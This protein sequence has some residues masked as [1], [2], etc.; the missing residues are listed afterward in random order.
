MDVLK[1]VDA[2][3]R[4]FLLLGLVEIKVMDLIFSHPPSLP[5]YVYIHYP[6]CRHHCSYCDFNV[7][8]ADDQDVGFSDL[9]RSALVS[10]LRYWKE[11]CEWGGVSLKGLY[12]GGGTP[13]LLSPEVI[14]KTLE[15]LK[16][17][18]LSFGDQTEVTI[19]CNP[20]S[21][22]EDKLIGFRDCGI[23]RIS[24]GIQS[25]QDTQL[26]R[27]ERLA[28]QKHIHASIGWVFKHFKNFSLD[29]MLG[30]PDQTDEL[31]ER[32]LNEILKVK[33]PHISAYILTLSEDHVWK[34]SSGMKH[35]MIQDERVE[36]FYLRLVTEL[37]Q[38]GFHHYEVSNF[39]RPGSES[40]HNKNYW[41]V[42]SSYL[43]LGPGAHGY[44]GK[45]RYES[46]RDPKAWMQSHHGIAWSEQLTLE[47][48]EIE[49]FYMTLR[50]RQPAQISEFRSVEIAALQ[51]AALI[52]TD[53]QNQNFTLTD[54]GWLLIESVAGRLVKP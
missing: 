27:L 50:T 31:F 14:R 6:L 13:S 12:L 8:R 2:S 28:T 29:L 25:F 30:L 37:K 24:L 44:L 34:T 17:E 33:P 11:R 3:G 20:E 54:R 16:S 38:A 39:A 35:R 49:K 4:V 19:E 53:Q 40:R 43:G 32:D 41:D 5:E 46:I 9:W 22:T 26:R 18:G 52:Q 51:Q 48:Q 1:F 7:Y 23:N 42:E 36:E 15:D 10:Q 45:C 21:L 47:Q